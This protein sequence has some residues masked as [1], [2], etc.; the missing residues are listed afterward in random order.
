MSDEIRD[1]LE[2][3]VPQA[4]AQPGNTTTDVDSDT[5]TSDDQGSQPDPDTEG[6][7]RPYERRIKS[8]AAR[9]KKAEEELTHWRNI[10]NRFATTDAKAVAPQPEQPGYPNDEVERAAR[11]LRERGFVTQ[12]EIDQKL[13]QLALRQKWNEV[14]SSNESKYNAPGSK[15]PRY[16]RD[17]VEE[18]ARENGIA[19]P[20]AAYRN[21]Y[22]DEIMDTVRKESRTRT[23]PGSEKPTRT[24]TGDREPMTIEAFRSKLAGPDGKAYYAE[25]SKDPAKLDAILRQFSQ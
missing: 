18:Y 12:D 1:E 13:E 9:A 3:G 17:E 19:D 5:G 10:A 23:G 4:G 21:M 22:F 24:P 15:Y 16:D 25:L 11:V 2:N 14:H 7:E 20:A 6:T 8:L